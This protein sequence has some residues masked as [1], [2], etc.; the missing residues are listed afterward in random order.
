[1]V[2]ELAGVA[3]KADAVDAAV[4][5]AAL[6]LDESRAVG[7]VGA[8]RPPGG[9]GPGAGPVFLP[10]LALAE[11]ATACSSMPHSFEPRLMRK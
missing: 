7:A 11:L 3:L 2:Y 5:V 9:D 1:M 4:F 8:L 10:H 6:R